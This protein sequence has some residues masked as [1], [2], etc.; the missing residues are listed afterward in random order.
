MLGYKVIYT[1]LVSTKASLTSWEVA[2]VALIGNPS[3]GGVTIKI[4]Y[5]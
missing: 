5:A 2:S 3:S 4:P 1:G